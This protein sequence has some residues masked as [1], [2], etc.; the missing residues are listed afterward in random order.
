MQIS[1]LCSTEHKE[2]NMIF[3]VSETLP[4]GRYRTHMARC[5]VRVRE[6]FVRLERFENYRMAAITGAIQRRAGKQWRRK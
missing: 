3:I 6:W 5:V 4:D 1:L 2:E